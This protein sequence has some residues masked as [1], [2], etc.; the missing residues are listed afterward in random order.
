[1]KKVL[2]SM[3]LFFVVI[4][5]SCTDSEG[6][7]P[8]SCIESKINDKVNIGDYA[9]GGVVFYID[10]TGRHG[11][12]IPTPDLL[13]MFKAAWW[14]DIAPYA[15]ASNPNRTTGAVLGSGAPNS[16]ILLGSGST[17]YMVGICD[18]LLIGECYDDWYLPSREELQIIYVNLNKLPGVTLSGEYYFSSTIELKNTHLIVNKAL[19]V[20]DGSTSEIYLTQPHNSLRNEISGQFIPV[21]SF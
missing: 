12:V 6:D 17:P 20:A 8:A 10:F 18:N 4:L 2:N 19:K 21:R 15:T 14:P 3:L 16:K 7:G 1:M 9:Y 5:L 11:M 13:H